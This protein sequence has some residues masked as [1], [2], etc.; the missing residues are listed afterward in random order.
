[1]TDDELRK[2]GFTVGPTAAAGMAKLLHQAAP[3]LAETVDEDELEA[4]VAREAKRFGWL[5]YHTK[6]S[7][8]SEAGF[9]DDILIRGNKLLAMELKSATGQPTAAQLT[10]LE[11]FAGVGT[12]KCGIWRPKD[13]DE[14]IKELSAD[15]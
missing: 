6:D 2:M 9:P 7:R 5:R 14:I 12:V 13:W 11:A 4:A 1:M 8:K 3:P 10:W 15:S